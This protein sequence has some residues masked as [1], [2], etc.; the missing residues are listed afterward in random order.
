MNEHVI[1]DVSPADAYITYNNREQNNVNNV[2][3]SRNKRMQQC[4]VSN[5]TYTYNV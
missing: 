2:L 5:R 4:P 1:Q 3:D